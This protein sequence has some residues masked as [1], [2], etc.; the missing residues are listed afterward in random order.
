[1]NRSEI[2]T[3][4]EYSGLSYN[5][6]LPEDSKG[7]IFAINDSKTD[8]SY[9]I[10][11]LDDTLIIAFRGSDSKKDWMF[12]LDFHKKV[13]PYNNFRS[14]IKVHSGFIN[15]YKSRNVRG[16]IRKFITDKIKK[17]KLTGHSYGAALAI[18]CAV[19][20][21]YS[22]NDR[23]YEVVVFGCPRIGNK[24]FKNSYNK[25]IFKT[26]RVENKND[27][28]TKVPFKI[29]GYCHVGS[30]VLIGKNSLTFFPNM[31]KHTLQ[32]YYSNIWDV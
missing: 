2:V 20:L 15:A 13:I 6:V 25:R 16:K 11:V 24:A 3:M 23:D 21:Q 8:V 22:F 14:K 5:D 19:D 26:L 29:M 7:K 17:I 10:R 32:E 28:I 31:A 27:I 4:L 18:L 9:S 1:M 30:R 12:N